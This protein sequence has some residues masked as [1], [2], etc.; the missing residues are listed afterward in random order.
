MNVLGIDIGGSGIKGAPVDTK[1]G[2]LVGKRLRI[3]TPQPATP[4]ACA[5]VVAQIVKHFNWHGPI[6]AAFPARIKKGVAMTASNIDDAWIHTNVEHLL[7]N[8]TGC[9][10]R[11]INDADAAG[12]AEMAFGKGR[13]RKDLVL[14]LTVGTGIGSALFTEGRLVPNTEFGHVDVLGQNGEHYAADRTRKREDLS[15]E[16]WAHRFQ[17]YLDRIE[18]LIS[19][20]L[21]IL[22]GGI[23][24]PKKAKEFMHLLKPEAE[25][26]TAKLQNEAGIIGA[27]QSARKLKMPAAVVKGAR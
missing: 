13:K 18:F 9:P 15:W 7:S 1:K 14:L 10:V 21:I 6:G 2:I 27:A 8:E 20:D 23:S 3:P 19:P 24:R 22:G 16:V 12:V 25:L 17:D 4:E 11:V 26:V 5:R